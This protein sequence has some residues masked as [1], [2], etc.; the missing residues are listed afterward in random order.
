MDIDKIYCS[1]RSY[2]FH[3][4]RKVTVIRAYITYI[5]YPTVVS[6]PAIIESLQ[7]KKQKCRIFRFALLLDT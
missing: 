6:N 1:I 7:K 3:S 4:L 2:S 5:I